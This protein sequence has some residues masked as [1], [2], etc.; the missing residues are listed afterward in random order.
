MS[1]PTYPR[2]ITCH[3]GI[4]MQSQ[5]YCSYADTRHLTDSDESQVYFQNLLL[6]DLDCALRLAYRNAPA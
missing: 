3:D 5:R 1:V 6:L 2:F 4:A